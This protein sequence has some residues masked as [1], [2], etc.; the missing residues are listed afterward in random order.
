MA[1]WHAAVGIRGCVA[2]RR[3][4]LAV[5]SAPAVP[6]RQPDEAR[7]TFRL[8][9]QITQAL[10]KSIRQG[11]FRGAYPGSLEAKWT[12]MVTCS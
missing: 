4:P 11:R 5:V 7:D 9:P 12:G 2:K 6:I 3:Q 8:R 1:S 10:L